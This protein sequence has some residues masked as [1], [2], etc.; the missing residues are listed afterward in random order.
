MEREDARKLSPEAQQER[1]RQV[2]RAY[3]CHECVLWFK[4]GRNAMG[5]MRVGPSEA[6]SRRSFQTTLS[7]CR[8]ERWW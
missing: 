1:R 7:C 3:V 2:V 6:V 5:E 4:Q 8:K